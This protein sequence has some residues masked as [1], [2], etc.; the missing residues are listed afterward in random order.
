M[1]RSVLYTMFLETSQCIHHQLALDAL[2]VFT[3]AAM[4]ND[5]FEKCREELKEQAKKV[6]MCSL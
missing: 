2:A 1:K 4:K 3:H 5:V 6:K